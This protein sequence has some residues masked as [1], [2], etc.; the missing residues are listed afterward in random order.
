LASANSYFKGTT[1]LW[2]VTEHTLL[3]SISPKGPGK[4]SQLQ[5]DKK[6]EQTKNIYELNCFSCKH[7]H[8]TLPSTTSAE[9]CICQLQMIGE[10][11]KG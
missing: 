4:A 11:A 3:Q 2:V 7:C 5:T 9:D 6:N 8:S 10:Q 1:A